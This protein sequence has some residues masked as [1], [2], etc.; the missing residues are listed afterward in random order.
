M[1]RFLK[2]FV[3]VA[4]M[5]SLLV[6]PAQA[7]D[8]NYWV[9]IVDAN[10]AEVTTGL[11]FTIYT[12]GTSTQATIYDDRNRG[13]MS[14][15]F[16][17]GTDGVA[18]WWMVASTCDIEVTDGTTTTKLSTATMTDHLIVFVLDYIELEEGQIDLPIGSMY[19]VY[20]DEEGAAAPPDSVQAITGEGVSMVSRVSAPNYDIQNSLGCIVWED[21]EESAVEISFRI[22]A[23][24]RSGGTFR[25]WANTSAVGGNDCSIDYAYYI[26]TDTA[27]ADTASDDETAIEVSSIFDGTGASENE[28]DLSCA[29]TFAVGSL[30]TLRLWR[31]DIDTGTGNLELYHA[32]FYYNKRL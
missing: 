5:L 14:N 10:G 9:R 4:F 27:T 15:A 6:L 24:Y 17:P 20:D 25:V 8:N 23:D 22:P 3:A 29:G 16:D 12:A 18:K 1:N 11:T 28:Y 31:D 32:T 21:G 19:I 26:N 2:V 13:S 30:V 7:R